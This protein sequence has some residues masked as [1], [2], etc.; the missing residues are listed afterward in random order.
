[1]VVRAGLG[2]SSSSGLGP[3]STNEWGTTVE[4]GAS[5]AGVDSSSRPPQQRTLELAAWSGHQPIRVLV[6][7][8]STGNY[9]DGQECATHGIKIE[10]EDQVEELRMADGT[11]AKTKG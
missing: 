10:A 3:G 5:T 2:P 6:G 1:M 9:I 7:S 8:G 4:V 11:M